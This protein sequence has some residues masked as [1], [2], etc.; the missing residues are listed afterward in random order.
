MSN[1]RVPLNIPSALANTSNYQIQFSLCNTETDGQIFLEKKS[2]PSDLTA[3]RNGTLT[4]TFARGELPRFSD[5]GEVELRAH[6]WKGQKLI[7]T[8]DC[9]II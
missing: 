1:I 3:G 2:S 8:V 9:G 5:D 7:E 4:A 6:F